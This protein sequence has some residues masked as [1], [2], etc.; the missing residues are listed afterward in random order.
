MF[1]IR[2]KDGL[3]R[4]GRLE[5]N[6]KVVETPALMPVINPK[7]NVI[8]PRELQEKFKVQMIITNAFIIHES[9]LKEKALE[10]GIHDLLGF[11]GIIE[12]DSGSFQLMTYGNINVTN[13][14]IITFQND[15][16]SDV[17][18]FLDIPT[19]PGAPYEEAENDLTET[20]QR[21]EEAQTIKK[22]AMN[23]TV[24][25]GNF[26]PL[27]KKASK[28]V[29]ALDFEMHPIGAVVPLLLK[30]QFTPL[31]DII[32]TCKK[33]LPVER[34]VHLFGAGHP[35]LLAFAVLL[36]CDLF[37][38]AA[39]V[40]YAQGNRYLTPFGTK[41][42]ED[43]LTFPCECPVCSGTDP[44]SV[45]HLPPEEKVQFLTNHNL[46]VTFGELRKIKQAIH[47]GSLWELV[48]SRIRNHPNLLE[49]YK[50]IKKY[51]PFMERFEPF[52]KRTGFFY[53]GAESKY[54]PVCKRVRTRMASVKGERFHHPIFGE[55]P[56]SLSQTYPF[57]TDEVF[58]IK[59]A[60]L[61]K[62][63]AVY[64]FGPRAECL[65]E[66]VEI[67]YGK[68]GKI[69]HVHENG[70]LLA[71]LRPMDG[72]F[73]LT[74]EGAQKLHKLLP[75]CDRRV[76]TDEEAVPF[77][78]EGRDLFAKFVVD[79]DETLRPNEE[80]LLVDRNDVLLGVGKLLL[81]PEEA[82]SF[83]K[84]VAVQCRR[85]AHAVSDP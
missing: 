58:T 21:A 17:S 31:V 40:L 55:V 66:K 57:H 45:S 18:T 67:M 15:I 82:K 32:L 10:K 30:Y 60:D 36:G 28:A 42:L 38:S 51:A 12:T 75:F 77:V 43:L 2:A 11:D 50:V 62:G 44:E 8:S 1:E 53:T 47:E 48:E 27:R 26:L 34:P 13:K 9:A 6:K 23:G 33:F 5:I 39:Y 29:G 83:K 74:M 25:G 61:I 63:V 7:K 70:V 73:V 65:F 46:Y 81:S 80:V 19:L 41:N 64:Q 79:L 59:E 68:T 35:L 72:L 3:G 52:T 22:G 84:G 56:V 85:G 54:R 37:D 78:K 20:L 14:E 69:R 24:Q 71:T 16:G 76:I 49:S 4:I